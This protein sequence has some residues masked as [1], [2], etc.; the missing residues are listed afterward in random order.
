MGQSGTK[1]DR[2]GTNPEKKYLKNRS[3]NQQLVENTKDHPEK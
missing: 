2:S 3:P 1:R